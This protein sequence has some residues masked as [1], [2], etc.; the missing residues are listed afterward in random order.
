[1]DTNDQNM[2]VEELET[3]DDHGKQEIAIIN[4]QP[5]EEDQVEEKEQIS[6]DNFEEMKKHLLGEPIQ[7][8]EVIGEAHFTWEIEGWRSMERKVHGPVFEC[9]GNPWRILFFPYGNG[10]NCASLYLE[11]GF[12]ETN[13]TPENWY[14]CAQFGLVLWNPREPTHFA[15]HMATHRFTLEEGDWG[16]TRFAE[17]PRLFHKDDEH[18]RPMVEDE[19]ANITAYVRVYKDPTGVLWH[20]FI[21]YDSK[22][23]TGFVGL[24]NQGATCYLNS[25]LQ[26]LYFTN[27][28]RKAV[29]QIPT[30]QEPITNSALALQR[31][32]YQLQTSNE[33]VGT[34]ELTRSFGWETRH[35]FEQQDVQELN[36]KLMESL[37]EKMKGT[38]AENSLAKMFVGKTKTYVN[39]INVDYTS[40]RVEDFWDIQLNVRNFNNLDES[41]KDY[42]AVETLDGE[43]KYFAEG[44]GLQ[45]AKKGVIFESFPEILHLHLKRFEYDINRDCMMKVNDHYE[46]PL[47]FDAEPYLSEDADKSE[48][49]K[50][51]LHGVLVHS[52]DFNAGHYYAFLK[53]NKDGH[54]Y[55][56]DDDRVTRATIREVTEENFGGDYNTGNNGLRM[57]PRA[58][59]LKRSMSAYMLVYL[60]QSRIDHI[61]P[62]LGEEDAPKHLK[63][64]FE[65]E[66]E[67]KEAKRR[68]KE[69]QHLYLQV[70]VIDNTHFKSHEGFDLAAWDDTDGEPAASPRAYKVLKN[71]PFGKL[72]ARVANDMNET[73]ERVRLW[74]MV[75]RQNKTVRP[76]QP[77]LDLDMTVEDACTKFGNKG[78]YF[79]LWAEV[80][81]P[82]DGM[83]G[84][85]SQA[86]LN[87]GTH[88]VI[89]LKL[90]DPETQT[91]RGINHV[92]MKKN[93]KVSD[94]APVIMSEMGWPSSTPLKLYEEI[95]PSMI[96]PMK[97]KQTFSQAE[98]QDGDI[99]C[100]QKQVSEKDATAYLSSDP[101]RFIDAKEFYENMTNRVL[102]KFL[103]KVEGKTFDLQLNK[104]MS[105]DQIAARVGGFLNVPPTHLRFWTMNH[106]T[107]SPRSVIKRTANQVLSQILQPSY[108]NYISTT[109]L[110]YEVLEIALSELETKKLL[111][112]TWLSDGISSSETF[113]LLV[114]KSGQVQDVLPILQQKAGLDDA[115][116]DKIRIFEGH[117]GK[118]L[119]FLVPEF[120]VAGIADYV[121]VFAE[122]VPDEELNMED[123]DRVINAFHFYREP[124][125]VHPRGIPFRF[126]VKNGEIFKQTKERLQKRTGLKGKPFE[127]I[128]FAV[129]K[130]SQFSKPQYLEDD[131]ILSDAITDEDDALGLDH[132]DKSK[133]SIWR[134]EGGVFIK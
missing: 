85:W 36:R 55:K 51:S 99:I 53:P 80:A 98:I 43:N 93:D 5:M 66:R 20:N 130:K 67:E 125:K 40:S 103:P 65:K 97:P 79:R 88:I 54:F 6:A 114:P 2:V 131:D 13:K 119:K 112:I 128:K 74:S 44:H 133:G 117:T 62:P 18:E 27:E 35:I 70:Q 109:G 83:P 37:E 77:I 96:E 17:L 46:F 101:A 91:L 115:V 9:A 50:Y 47:E 69:E 30:E 102:V 52:G 16:F 22:K 32:F 127:K 4:P 120:S 29:Y 7:D 75:N 15:A 122:K 100:F 89:F 34:H 48:P 49:Y 81:P 108:H 106:H 11:H 73:P 90:F 21:N 14:S 95:K 39:C 124:I 60:R 71:D 118:M 132:V 82:V 61:L 3:S 84:N 59:P 64:R 126:V 63:E 57:A 104:K 25:L 134:T 76:D 31:L 19:R 12:D 72:V 87:S 42:I 58:T 41:F 111:K 113:D 92:Y 10:Y 78:P 38:E 8:L 86:P 116:M 23:E 107:G 123:G 129:V 1:M 94:L 110:F 68:E 28:F 26:S 56:F 33:A 121:D 105:Y 45:D 24:K